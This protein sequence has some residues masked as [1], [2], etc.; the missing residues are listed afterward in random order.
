[1][2]AP[3][4]EH[5]RLLSIKIRR[6]IAAI[7]ASSPRR[8]QNEG[9]VT[10]GAGTY[11]HP[12]V[13]YFEGDTASVRIG[14]Y[15]SISSD[16]TLIPGGNH[17]VDWASTYPFRVR[18]GLKGAGTDGHPVAKGD[19]VVGNDVWIGHGSTIMSGVQ[20]GDG[21]V[22]AACS[23]VTKDVPSYAIV[24]GNPAKVIGQRF[25]ADQQQALLE[26]RWWDWPEAQILDRVA[27]LNGESVDG[28][29]QRYGPPA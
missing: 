5:V 27:S 15:C 29:L 6:R 16:V 12:R 8:L 9:L 17:R 20:I 24:G 13:L 21:A 28:F 22:I 1:M 3:W 23:L 18:Y 26:I 14:K 10:F 11:G 2:P 25:N 19:I 4:D 7:R